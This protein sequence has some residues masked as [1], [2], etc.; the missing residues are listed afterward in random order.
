MKKKSKFW[1]YPLII[2]GVFLML[3][4]NCKKDKDTDD[5]DAN[6]KGF[7]EF[8]TL[9]PWASGKKSSMSL[10]STTSN[11][12]LTGDTTITIMTSMN[13]CVGDVWVSQGE[14][15]A[16]QPDNLEWIRLTNSTNQDLKLFENYSF[17]PVELPEGTYRSIKITF[18]NIFYRHTEL[19]SDP[20]IKYELLETMGSSFDPCDENDTSWAK[21]N[22]FSTDGNHKLNDNDVFELVAPGEKVGGF[23]IEE[24]KTAIV[25]WRLGGG[26]TEPCINYLF[27]LNGNLE[28]DCGI[29]DLEDECPPEMENMFDFF[30]EYE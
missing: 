30:V 28:W 3:T 24:G 11:P 20:S 2:M 17:N 16:G 12:P 27:D 7:L 13:V 25:S 1:I 26:V 18:K 9:N 21:T 19:V 23:T 15:K 14:V 5:N 29:D 8:K 22:Y 4:S 10:K 6:K